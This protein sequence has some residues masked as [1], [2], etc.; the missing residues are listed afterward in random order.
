L[1]ANHNGLLF[2]EC[3]ELLPNI[4][5]DHKQ[6]R[7]YQHGNVLYDDLAKVHAFQGIARQIQSQTIGYQIA[8]DYVQCKFE[9]ALPISTLIVKSKMLVEKIAEDTSEEVITK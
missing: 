9:D 1:T 8:D 3:K 7:A 2:L 4:I 5:Y 6:H